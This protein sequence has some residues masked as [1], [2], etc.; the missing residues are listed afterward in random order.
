[1]VLRSCL[2]L[3]LSAAQLFSQ[4]FYLHDGDRVV[5]Y[6]DSITDQ[7][8]YTTFVE[9]F[10]VTRFPNMKV[11]FVHSGWGGDRVTGGGGGPIDLRLQRDVF[12]YKPTVVTIMLGMNDGGYKAFD[13]PTFDTFS[14]GYQHIIES[15]QKADPGVRITL[16]KPSP[17]DDVTQAPKF[18]GGYNA[19]LVRYGDYLRD[20]AARDHADFAD[21]NTPV[22][23]DLKKARQLDAVLAP[24]LIPDR[25]HPGPAGH[26]LMAAALLH[27]WHAPALVTSVEID[28][29]ARRLV[30]AQNTAVT[31]VKGLFWTQQDKSLPMPI[32]YND[33]D[34]LIPLA[35]KSSDILDT[36]DAQ[37][38]K[39]TGLE[40][41]NYGLKIDGN[42]VAKFTA[43]ELAQGVNLSRFPT[44]MSQ[45]ALDVH[46]WTLKRA[47]VHNLR[48][49]NIEVPF[50]EMKAS[51]KDAVMA[52]LD[53]L[54]KVLATKQHEAA[55]PALHNYELSVLP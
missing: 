38:L 22:V 48:W 35:V 19:V 33:K 26:L 28:G 52:D 18:E 40:S 16:I 34:K 7:R 24:K 1:M 23:E 13:Q 27:D 43:A 46:Q 32:D 20:L 9:S 25:V 55:R 44:P 37:M 14:N 17:F 54:D 10:V 49:R 41:G 11:S 3:A 4:A 6:G 53:R 47:N 36:L 31:N 8:L 50:Q 5:F 51:E 15:I 45:Q 30:K 21:L 39:V 42:E 29:A 2:L 12:P